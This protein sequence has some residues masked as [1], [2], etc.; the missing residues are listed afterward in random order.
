MIRQLKSTPRLL[1]YQGILRDKP[2]D[3]VKEVG[4]IDSQT[5][6]DDDDPCA[7]RMLMSDPAIR[8]K[9][10]GEAHAKTVCTGELSIQVCI[11][12]LAPQAGRY[13][14]HFCMT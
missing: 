14:R 9:R 5:A 4:C 1:I 6:R 2:E 11:L 10:N 8:W 12:G 7:L 13:S 3:F